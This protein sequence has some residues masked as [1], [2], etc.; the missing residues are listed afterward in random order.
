M[1]VYTNQ[2]RKSSGLLGWRAH[3]S[4]EVGR[5]LRK[6]SALADQTAKQYGIGV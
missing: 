6:S 5:H 3:I 4:T 2:A 1:F